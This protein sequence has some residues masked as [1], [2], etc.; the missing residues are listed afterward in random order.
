MKIKIIVFF[1]VAEQ[2]LS[3]HVSHY[4]SLTYDT[5]ALHGRHNRV[6]RSTYDKVITLDLDAFGR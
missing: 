4:E 6:R 5:D 1:L 3:E 2:R